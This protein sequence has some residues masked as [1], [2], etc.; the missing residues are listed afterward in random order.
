M[1]QH[2][3]D[4]QTTITANLDLSQ[5]Q[6]QMSQFINQNYKVNVSVDTSSITNLQSQLRN[7]VKDL[8]ITPQMQT[9]NILDSANSVIN[10]INRV[11]DSAETLSGLKSNLD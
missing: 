10:T 9:G 7:S 1:I 5:A 8:T 6:A 4:N 2:M 3:S 11:R